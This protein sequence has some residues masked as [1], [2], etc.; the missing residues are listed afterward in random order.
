VGLLVQLAFFAWLFVVL[1]VTSFDSAF[2]F[3]SGVET[4]DTFFTGDY[5]HL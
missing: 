3:F 4:R 5:C 2:R 1:V